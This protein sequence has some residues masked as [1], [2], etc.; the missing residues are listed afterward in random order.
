M[1]TK[2]VAN[3]RLLAGIC[4][5]TLLF[6]GCA[7]KQ[8]AALMH[9]KPAGISTSASVSDVPF[10]PQLDYQCGPASLAMALSHA[11]T[12]VSPDE[13]RGKLF[14]PGKQGSLQVEMM[15]LPRGYGQLAYL[16]APHLSDILREIEAGHPVIVF[17]NLGLSLAPQWHYAVV[18]GFDLAEE[19]ITLHSGDTPDY[20]IPLSTFEH[21]WVRAGSWAMVVQPAGSFP[22]GAEESSYLRAAVNLEQA[23]FTEAALKSYEAAV[24]RW[25][26]SLSAWMGLGN[27]RYALA[28]LNGAAEA[29]VRAAEAHTSA[30]EPL[31][32]LAQVQMEQGHFDE[33]MQ[34]VEQAVRLDGNSALY[35][36]TRQEVMRTRAAIEKKS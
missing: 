6:S 7:A 15:A 17:Q 8:S 14:I 34:A 32:N 20:R 28:D 23:G 36:Q 3:A 27:I 29:F 9:E 13:L 2:I 25:P 18:T 26:E 12:S 1:V 35:Q 4:L 21:T 11:G 31:N 16:L 22:A 33:A 24:T 19:S 5:I 30:A 10:F